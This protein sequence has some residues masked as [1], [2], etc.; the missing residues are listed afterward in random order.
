MLREGWNKDTSNDI[1][2]VI[3]FLNCSNLH[4]SLS[5]SSARSKILEKAK[6]DRETGYDVCIIASGADVH[7]QV[8]LCVC[9]RERKRKVL[10]AFYILLLFLFLI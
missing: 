2:R 7:E 6:K 4:L 5:L 3:H 10:A 9:V 1:H 8:C